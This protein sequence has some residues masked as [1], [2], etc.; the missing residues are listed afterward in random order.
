MTKLKSKLPPITDAEEADIQ[1]EIAANP[2]HPEA[3]DK[4]LATARPFAE[5]F[6]ALADSINRGGRPRSESLREKVTIRLEPE[7]LAKFKAKGRG[8]QTL[9]NDVLKRARI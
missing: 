8:W 7:V 6:P 1:R 4:E 2:E 9:I 5:A 3:T